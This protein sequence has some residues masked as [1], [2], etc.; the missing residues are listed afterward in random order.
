MFGDSNGQIKLHAKQKYEVLSAVS[1]CPKVN[2]IARLEFEL[3]YYDSA[4]QRFNHY[5]NKCAHTFAKGNSPKVNVKAWHAFE[6][7]YY[8]VAIL[9]VSHWAPLKSLG[10]I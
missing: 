1:I 9:Y 2:A 4:A 7:V 10:S 3:A 6:L 8:D 5:T